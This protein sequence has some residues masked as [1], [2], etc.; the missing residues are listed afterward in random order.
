MIVL[1]RDI[2]SWSGWKLSAF[3]K[4]IGALIL[5][6]PMTGKM[7]GTIQRFVIQHKELG[8]PRLK[9]N[10]V[11]WAEVSQQAKDLLIQWLRR[12]NPFVWFFLK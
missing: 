5:H 8:D 3:K 9:A 4:E 6:K 11:K 10:R 12:E 1:F 7:Q 2:L